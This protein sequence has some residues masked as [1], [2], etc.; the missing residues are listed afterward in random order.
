MLRVIIMD[1]ISSA[2]FS[3]LFPDKSAGAEWMLTMIT[4]G[5]MFGVPGAGAGCS[6]VDSVSGGRCLE[7]LLATTEGPSRMHE[8]HSL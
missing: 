5:T 3:M 6:V 2:G 4:L 8:A 7:R 1:V